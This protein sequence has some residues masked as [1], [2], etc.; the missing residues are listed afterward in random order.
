M[1][2]IL[3]FGIFVDW[4]DE[5]LSMLLLFYRFLLFDGRGVLEVIIYIYIYIKRER[6]TDWK[7]KGDRQRKKEKKK[8]RKTSDMISVS[9]N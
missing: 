4:A 3:L 5:N 6:E 9:S 8:E 2:W 1:I 7:K